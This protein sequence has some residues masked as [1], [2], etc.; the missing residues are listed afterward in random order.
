MAQA[1]NLSSAGAVEER[2]KK[3]KE[4]E[5][6][7]APEIVQTSQ[8]LVTR[9]QAMQQSQQY[10]QGAAYVPTETQTPSGVPK[11][12]I[13][14]ISELQQKDYEKKQ[15][16]ISQRR[17]TGKT[18]IGLNQDIT[19]GELVSAQ[20]QTAAGLGKE[21][22]ST[23]AQVIDAVT[24]IFRKGG[25]TARAQQAEEGFNAATSIISKDIEMIKTGDK[26][27]VDTIADLER[28]VQAM[29]RLEETA[30]G[31]GKLNLRY[32]IDEG[33]QLET[34]VIN[35]RV[36]LENLRT[37]IINAAVNQQV[38]AQQSEVQRRR[39]EIISAGQA[40]K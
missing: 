21:I 37:E 39:A 34:D 18:A 11:N 22:L 1:R 12:E 13:P 24:S 20:A 28:A 35:Q 15:E 7:Q 5:Q 4:Q 3:K 23:G 16:T 9:Q 30:H 32:W 31:I 10:A 19:R 40:S 25:K 36:I 29:N 2:K 14:S 8:G 38:V 26:S 6:V 17:E 27:Y 33:K